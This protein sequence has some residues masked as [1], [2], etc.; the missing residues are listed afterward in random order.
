MYEFDIRTQ[1]IGAHLGGQKG[2]VVMCLHCEQPACKLS[3]RGLT[4][5]F[6]HRII[7][8]NGNVIWADRCKSQQA[9]EW[10]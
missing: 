9:P 10:L 8:Q 3:K 5:K 4:H 1:E 6:A 7:I 2:E